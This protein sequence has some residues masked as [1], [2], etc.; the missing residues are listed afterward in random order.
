MIVA[1]R[2]RRL[3]RSL[4]KRRVARDRG[5]QDPGREFAETAS[6]SQQTLRS[7]LK[8]VMSKTGVSRQAE[9]V[10]LL[11]GRAL[12]ANRPTTAED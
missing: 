3:Y 8:G 9:L 12:P 2:S 1:A 7:Q 11:V 6:L 4:P 5:R 10:A